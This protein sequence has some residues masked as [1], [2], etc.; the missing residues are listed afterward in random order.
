MEQRRK[1][2]ETYVRFDLSA[3]DAVAELGYPTPQALRLWY[4]DY[5]EHGEVRAP[6]RQR[7][8]RFTDEMK[9]AAVDYYLEHGRSLARTMR[10][11]GY[12]AGREYLCAWIDA[13]APGQRKARLRPRAKEP[14]SLEERIRIAAE[15]EAREGTADDVAR[16]HGVSRC[17]AYHWRRQLLSGD[18]DGTGAEHGRKPV[19]EGCDRLPEDVGELREMAEGLRLQVRRLQL[20][21]DVRNATLEII[22]K[23]PGTDPNRLTNREKALLVGSLRGKWGLGELLAAAGMAKSS[24]EYAARAA[25]RPDRVEDRVVRDA[26]VKAFNDNGGAYGYRRILPEVRDATGSEVGEWTVRRVMAENGLVACNPKRRRRYSSYV[27]EV[28]EA[29]ENTCLDGRGRHDFGA[30][31]PNELWVTDITE[32]RMPAGKCYLS[33]VI[34]CFDGMPV[35][36]SIGTSPDADLANSSLLQACAQLKEG[37]HPRSHSDR[38]GHYRWPGWVSICEE[39]G[40]V[41]SMSRRG[42]SPDNSRAEG[43]FGRLKVE[44]FYG[45]DWEGVTIEEFMGTLHGY[46]VWY[47]DE[48][49]KSDLGYRSPT[50]YRRELGL[51]A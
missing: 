11:M 35:G 42:C 17:A 20:E 44:F 47:R 41:R 28:S 50:Q 2:I 18:N 6:K 25:T 45:R 3:A 31:R 1:A 51:A 37:E 26:V 30:G 46:M 40:L 38:G 39:H 12:P 14:P 22:K 49:R 29:P 43:F 13:L 8:P 36:W 21:L 27:G 9:R 32:F 34:D 48:R 16:R 10:K 23:D 19:G 33:P 5:L 7:E 4:K 24:Y 15:L